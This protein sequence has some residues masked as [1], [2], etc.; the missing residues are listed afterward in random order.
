MTVLVHKDGV[1]RLTPSIQQADR[2]AREI[3]WV[4]LVPSARPRTPAQRHVSLS[5]ARR[6]RRSG[7]SH[8]PKIEPCDKF[9]CN[10]AAFWLRGQGFSPDR[11]VSSRPY[12]LV[13][14]HLKASRSMPRSIRC[15]RS[16]VRAWRQALLPPS[17]IID[18]GSMLRSEWTDWKIGWLRSAPGLRRRERQS[19]S[20][21]SRPPSDIA[22]LRRVTPAARCRQSPRAT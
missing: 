9:L 5:E 6:R 12:S 4:D 2:Q 15:S 21:H 3:V 13:T 8:H 17:R 14:V 1:L 16:T 11:R 7:E 19:A 10:P 20:G 22:S 18:R